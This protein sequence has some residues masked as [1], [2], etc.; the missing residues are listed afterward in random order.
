MKGTEFRCYHCNRDVTPATVIEEKQVA[1]RWGGGSTMQQISVPS[2]NCPLCGA[3]LWEVQSW[4]ATDETRAY[5]TTAAMYKARESKSTKRMMKNA[6]TTVLYVQLLP[7]ADG[8]A[9]KANKD[10]TKNLA[11]LRTLP[12]VVFETV[13]K[14]EPMTIPAPIPAP[15]VESTPAPV[16]VI[17]HTPAKRK[18]KP[19]P[20]PAPVIEETPPST[21]LGEHYFRA[22]NTANLQ[23]KIRADYESDLVALRTAFNA[24]QSENE[25]LRGMIVALKGE[26]RTLAGW[27]ARSLE[28]PPAPAPVNPHRLNELQREREYGAKLYPGSRKHNAHI[29]RLKALEA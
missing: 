28:T 13:V 9:S 11:T 17:I 10:W 5:T 6:D 12:G 24:Q 14:L 25:T 18:A 3:L 2:D 29:E 27:A 8:Y 7:M 20:A 22:R 1:T 15:V 26:I 23:A 19:A 16:E 4:K 21:Y